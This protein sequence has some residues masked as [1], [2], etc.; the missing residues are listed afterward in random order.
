MVQLQSLHTEKSPVIAS[1][2]YV[3]HEADNTAVASK[4]KK[5]KTKK[6]KQKGASVTE[7]VAPLPPPRGMVP[8]LNSLGPPGVTKL[9]VLDPRGI[10]PA[11]WEHGSLG[12]LRQA[13]PEPVP[14]TSPR[15]GRASYPP[16]GE[17]FDRNESAF[18]RPKT[19]EPPWRTQDMGAHQCLQPSPLQGGLHDRELGY[20]PPGRP[21][22]PFAH[23]NGQAFLKTMVSENG[24]C[25]FVQ[26]LGA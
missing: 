2:N 18:E 7:L 14:P 4:R 16:S 5:D 17:V 21:D 25:C 9:G 12:P 20:S 3:E 15:M 8:S 13:P 19:P 24:C 10:K 1:D 6:K 22:G 23:G 26:S 11:P